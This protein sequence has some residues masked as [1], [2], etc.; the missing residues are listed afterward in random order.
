LPNL[1]FACR[2]NKPRSGF[3]RRHGREETQFAFA[4][5]DKIR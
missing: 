3:R 5:F 1:H 4:P 2:N